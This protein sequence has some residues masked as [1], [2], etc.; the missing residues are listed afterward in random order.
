M[1]MTRSRC[2]VMR[3]LMV[4]LWFLS[5]FHVRLWFLRFL[6]LNLSKSA[7]LCEKKGGKGNLF[8]KEINGFMLKVTD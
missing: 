1:K 7:F 6:Y 4:I 5:H 8:L 3:V 2:F